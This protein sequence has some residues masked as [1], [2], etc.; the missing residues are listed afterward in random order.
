MTR[1]DPLLEVFGFGALW[2]VRG[3]VGSTDLAAETA[4]DP[5]SD[6][7]IVAPDREATI[8]ASVAAQIEPA[9]PAD[10]APAYGPDHAS[11][12]APD[13]APAVAQNDRMAAPLLRSPQA[14]PS[15][16]AHDIATLDFAALRERV[17]SCTD[18]SLCE[19]RTQ[20]VFGVGDPQADWLFVG[21][22][23]GMNEDQQGEPFVGQAGRLLDNMLL[24]LGLQRGT[25]V[26]IANVVKCRPPG[27]RD[28]LPD[29]V[30]ACAPYL[31][32]QIALI[33][34]KVIVALGRFAAQTLLSSD[35]KIGTLRGTVHRYE[36]VPVIVT[37]HPA[38][39]LRTLSDKAKAWEDLCL[40]RSTLREVVSGNGEASV[41]AALGAA[42]VSA[43]PEANAPVAGV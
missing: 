31:R 8:P 10:R 29:E 15:D 13:H 25:G 18:C 20:A 6:I 23:P 34:P 33:R 21:E 28:P 38:Y 12:H 40:A 2:R 9:L 3:A 35:A 11:A 22:G 17:V 41:G 19:T 7:A 26:F 30:A 36:G 16:R 43:G 1:P 37:Y 14:V 5:A 39:L 27:N 42:S 4:L 32:R 24:A